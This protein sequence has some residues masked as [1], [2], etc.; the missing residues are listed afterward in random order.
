MPNHVFRQNTIGNSSGP[1]LALDSPV[2]EIWAE[3]DMAFSSAWITGVLAQSFGQSLTGGGF[4]Y[5]S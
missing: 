2:S 5:Y 3:W 4:R 1:E